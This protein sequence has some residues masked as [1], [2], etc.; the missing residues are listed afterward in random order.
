[1]GHI[2][3]IAHSVLLP[4]T[5]ARTTTATGSATDVTGFADGPVG[6][7]AVLDNGTITGTQGTLDVTIEECATTNGSFST[8][9][10]FAQRTTTTGSEAKYFNLTKQY[11]RAV[12]TTG[13]TSPSFV[14]NVIL[15]GV[16]RL[17]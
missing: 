13:G 5:T 3:Q 16:D 15:Y 4:A 9:A 2:R 1:M 10:T 12:G 17:V 11:V 7:L 14:Y 6:F 8:V